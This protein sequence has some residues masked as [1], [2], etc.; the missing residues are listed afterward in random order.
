MELLN[1]NLCVGRYGRVLLHRPLG[2]E[3]EFAGT[4]NSDINR[5]L[6][7]D[8]RSMVEDEM[9][10]KRRFV[11]IGAAVLLLLACQVVTGTIPSPEVE[12]TMTR[13]YAPTISI[14]PGSWS[15][16][17]TQ[18]AVAENEFFALQS[19]IQADPDTTCIFHF[20]SLEITCL[21]RNG[22]RVY[23]MNVPT[24]ISQCPDGRIYLG[25]E[26]TLYLYDEHAPVKTIEAGF[27][28]GF[29]GTLACGPGDEFW[30]VGG[31]NINHFDGLAWNRYWATG[32]LGYAGY[33]LHN[34][35]A[36]A[37]NGN[38]W[39]TTD[40]SIATFDGTDWQIFESDKNFMGEPTPP[41]GLV[42]D[43]NGAVW[44]ITAA[45][46]KKYDGDQ[47]T[48]F[49][50]PDGFFA[51][52]IT[53]DRENRIWIA[54]RGSPSDSE[55]GSSLYS[56]DP[57]TE[58][59]TLQF[60]REVL[61]GAIV[62]MMQFDA[63]GRL[64]IATD[65]GLHIHDGTAWTAYH[66]F[67]SDLYS[68]II[69]HIIALGDGPQLPALSPKTP[70]S[71]RGRLINSGTISYA[72]LQ[73]ELC[74]KQVLTARGEKTPCADQAYHALTTMDAEGNF[75]FT[76]IPVGKYYLVIQLSPSEWGR[77]I[78]AGSGRASAQIEVFPGLET[79][80][81]EFPPTPD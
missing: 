11:I 35:I 29:A 70:G 4:I 42:V 71:V 78:A 76:D 66:T 17:A 30:V 55:R 56:F 38:I 32:V 79:W 72:G 77:G 12:A 10:Q 44:V 75:L 65:Y 74:L 46:L 1:R 45:G 15:L 48:A 39:V 8:V 33:E 52:S 50:A 23:Y 36:I 14:P 22:W 9:L 54:G 13:D 81:G 16:G 7:F 61:N 43:A 67:T 63:R 31:G 51:D 62:E 58:N 60:D 2:R 68:N 80:L 20:S 6:A 53:Q 73:V 19:N 21:D 64:W 24:F 5:A 34:E 41:R 3:V 49:S 69:T 57:Q 59:W 28:V 18:R 47:W 27:Q 25:R 26:E 37:P 40:E